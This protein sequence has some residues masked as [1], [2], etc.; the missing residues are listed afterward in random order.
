M[1]KSLTKTQELLD[2]IQENESFLEGLWMMNIKDAYLIQ[3]AATFYAAG[4]H[5]A[6]LEQEITKH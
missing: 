1:T 5:D 2:N 3:L 6:L 4:Y